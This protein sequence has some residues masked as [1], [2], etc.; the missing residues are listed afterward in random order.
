MDGEL[1]YGDAVYGFGA[2][3]FF[4]GYF[5]P[6]TPTSKGRIGARRSESVR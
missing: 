4:I 1:H 2:G 3:I 6:G 5:L